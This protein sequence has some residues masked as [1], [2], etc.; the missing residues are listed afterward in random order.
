MVYLITKAR[1]RHRIVGTLSGRGV[2]GLI[3]KAAKER[4]DSDRH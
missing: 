2:G 3:D 4:S 1:V